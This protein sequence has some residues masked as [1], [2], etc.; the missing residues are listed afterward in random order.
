MICPQ[1]PY[2]IVILKLRYS[3]FRIVLNSLF[4]FIC[5]P[6]Q[7]TVFISPHLV[8]LNGSKGGIVFS[9]K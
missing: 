3:N 4:H 6:H 2:G 9:I 8:P 5:Y 1:I 7:D